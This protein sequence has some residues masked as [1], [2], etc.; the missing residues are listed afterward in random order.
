MPAAVFDYEAVADVYD[1]VRML[2]Y[3]FLMS[4]QYD[5]A[6]KLLVQSL[7]CPEH[8]ISGHGIQISRWFVG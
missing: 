4:D 7:E 5:G 2:G 3:V 1:P 8:D 6:F